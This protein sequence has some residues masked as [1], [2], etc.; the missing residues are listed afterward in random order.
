MLKISLILHF[1][2]PNFWY[3]I[4]VELIFYLHLHLLKFC[5]TKDKSKGRI[6]N[7]NRFQYNILYFYQKLGDHAILVELKCNRSTYFCFSD[8]NTFLV[9]TFHTPISHKKLDQST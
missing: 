5:K 1:H 9:V 6:Q 2:T 7:I 3:G 8:V 4:V